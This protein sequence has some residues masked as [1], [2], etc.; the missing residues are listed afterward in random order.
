MIGSDVRR[1]GPGYPRNRAAT[2]EP[3]LDRG[4]SLLT[5]DA[6]LCH[7]IE[8]VVKT[9]LLRGV[10]EICPRPVTEADGEAGASSVTGS[11]PM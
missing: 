5:T 6:K 11:G 8:G 3:A 2:G 10:G 7:A 9:E 4:I 1:A